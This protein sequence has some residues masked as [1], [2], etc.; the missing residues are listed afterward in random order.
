[1]GNVLSFVALQLQTSP[2]VLCYRCKGF[3]SIC[4]L[5]HQA[6]LGS[7]SDVLGYV[8]LLCIRILHSYKEDANLAS[9]LLYCG[10]LFKT[11]AFAWRG[12]S[13]C[14]IKGSHAYE[15][16]ENLHCSS[17]A[18]P[19]HRKFKRKTLQ[20]DQKTM[21]AIHCTGNQSKSPIHSTMKCWIT[22]L[23]YTHLFIK[24]Y[25]HATLVFQ[26]TK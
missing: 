5:G 24:R 11:I 9:C 3:F 23:N 22:M 26:S 18:I 6:I 12:S 7:I 1:M 8:Y 16:Q 10:V 13:F 17:H 4:L 25:Q 20:S 21:G 15:L 19:L 2:L 14:M